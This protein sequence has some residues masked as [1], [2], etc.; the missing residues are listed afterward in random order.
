MTLTN[1]F[2][3]YWPLLLLVAWFGY[4]AWN[5]SRVRAMLPALKAQG[6]TLIDVRQPTEFNTAHAPGSINIPLSELGSRLSEIPRTAPVVLGCASGT[7]SG[8]A[9]M[10]LRKNGFEQVHNIGAWTKFL[11]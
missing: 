2:E 8:M 6:A 4:K 9:K 1:F 5:S 11:D 10:L 7:R 3:Q